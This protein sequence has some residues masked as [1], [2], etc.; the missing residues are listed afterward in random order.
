M[1]QA[2]LHRL[3]G[4]WHAMPAVYYGHPEVRGCVGQYND[5]G[6]K[7]LPHGTSDCRYR[8]ENY[9]VI[10]HNDI[11]TVQVLVCQSVVHLQGRHACSTQSTVFWTFSD[12]TDRCSV[13]KFR[14]IQAGA[15]V[16]T[17]FK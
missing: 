12:E 14:N 5:L 15:K 17:H 11:Y 2:I 6:T 13:K 8:H 4:Q 16:R 3:S 1:V 7:T 9:N 10:K